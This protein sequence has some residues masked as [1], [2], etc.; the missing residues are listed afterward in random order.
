MYTKTDKYSKYDS[1][2][3]LEST[4]VDADMI[5]T[6]T[7]LSDSCFKYRHFLLVKRLFSINEDNLYVLFKCLMDIVLIQKL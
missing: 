4:L 2:I 1:Q 3:S 5:C 6:Y 7:F